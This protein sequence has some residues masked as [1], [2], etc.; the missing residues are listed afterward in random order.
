MNYTGEFTQQRLSYNYKNIATTDV[1]V[2]VSAGNT[3]F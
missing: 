1:K 3:V 2:I